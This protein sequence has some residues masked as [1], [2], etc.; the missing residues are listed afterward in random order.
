MTEPLNNPAGRIPVPD[1]SVLTTDIV[2]LAKED[3]RREGEMMKEAGDAVIIA[4]RVE[5]M[6]EIKRLEDVENERLL[7]IDQRFE[8]RDERTDQI[9]Q[10]GRISLDAALAAAKEAVGEQNKSNALSITKS[11]SSMKEQVS[12]NAVQAGTRIDAL[13][14]KFDDLKSR[15]DRGEGGTS[16]QRYERTEHRSVQTLSTNIMVGVGLVII[17]ALALIAPHIH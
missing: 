17:G 12:A 7:R 9:A 3:L 13:S 11:E 6:G 5:L 14:D 2:N 10:L 1:P 15:M 4:L 8:E 16:G